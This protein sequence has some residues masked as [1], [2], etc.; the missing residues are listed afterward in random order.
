MLLLSVVNAAHLSRRLKSVKQKSS[1][2]INAGRGGGTL[3]Q[4]SLTK[5][6]YTIFIA[7]DVVNLSRLMATGTGNTALTSVTSQL[8]SKV[9][10]TMSEQDFN[11]EKRY[12]VALQIADTLLK[13]GAVSEDEYRQIKTKLLEKYR[14]ILS[15]LLSG[16]PLM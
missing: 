7:P 4:S 8:G 2:P 10:D 5:K 16:N 1:V 11:C 6:L 15:T 9:V 13:N 12:Q 14:P 3:T